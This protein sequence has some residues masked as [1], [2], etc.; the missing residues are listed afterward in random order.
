MDPNSTQS[1]PLAI[2]CR[3]AK[4]GRDASPLL[5]VENIKHTIYEHGGSRLFFELG[6][7]RKLIADSYYDEKFARAMRA[8][9]EEYFTANDKLRDAAQ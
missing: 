2:E 9:V 5:A 3:S 7:E 4:A 1:E 8:F 6:P